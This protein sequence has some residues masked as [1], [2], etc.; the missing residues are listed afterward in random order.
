MT[1]VCVHGAVGNFYQSET[2][3]TN[4]DLESPKDQLDGLTGKAKKDKSKKKK[5]GGKKHG[6]GTLRMFRHSGGSLGVNG[7]D[8][9]SPS[10]I[11][12]DFSAHS[13]G[14]PPK[15]DR[16]FYEKELAQLQVE[17]VK[18]QYWIKHTG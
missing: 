14:R 17:L 18:M 11:L 10:P 13:E 8:Q 12:D 3:M 16:R 7:G 4:P 2:S 1:V 9:Y 5:K 6:K 15:L